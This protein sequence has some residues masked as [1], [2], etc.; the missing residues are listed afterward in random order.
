MH[1]NAARTPLALAALLTAATLTACHSPSGGMFPT[2]D[3][4]TTYYST[5]LQ[6][7][8]VTM[9]DMRTDEVIWSLDVPPDQQLTFQFFE[10]EG[11]DP[12]YTPALMR[13]AIFPLGKQTGKLLNT[14]SVPSSDTRKVVVEYREGVE[15]PEAP[16]DD[17]YR[18]DQ[19]AAL[20]DWHDSAAG[21][22]PSR[23]PQLANYDN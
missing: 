10:G 13:W 2:R 3:G 9:V 19:T 18:I 12:V 23:D 4:S 6:P 8:S 7:A 5:Q 17:V 20:P 21:P 11:D 1:V 22:L 15:Y 14:M 16:D